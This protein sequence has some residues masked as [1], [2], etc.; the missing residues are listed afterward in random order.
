MARSI[1]VHEN[2]WAWALSHLSALADIGA[3]AREYKAFQRPRGVR[4]P[5]DQQRRFKKTTDSEHGGPVAP[6][7]LDQDFTAEKP[8]E[9]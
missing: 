6:N 8:N 1:L 2:N 4:N 5:E 9:K 7:V 3:T